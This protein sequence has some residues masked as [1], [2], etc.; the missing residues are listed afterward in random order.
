MINTLAPIAET[1]ANSIKYMHRVMSNIFC[2]YLI[3]NLLS[4]WNLSLL[5]NF[6]NIT[7][8]P[9]FSRSMLE[10]LAF[11]FYKMNGLVSWI[12]TVLRLPNETM[13]FSYLIQRENM[14]KFK[15]GFSWFGEMG[16]ST[17][18]VNNNFESM[19]VLSMLLLKVCVLRIVARV[20]PTRLRTY[21]PSWS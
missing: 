1:M 8:V 11:I 5:Y 10:S 9:L 12:K 4:F 18:F 16:M 15:R 20:L 2:S 6:L 14:P 13:D 19:M 3:I 7:T 17:D 21:L